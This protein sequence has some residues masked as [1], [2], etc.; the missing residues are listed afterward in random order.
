MLRFNFR[1]TE[2][3][4]QRAFNLGIL[5]AADK[6]LHKKRDSATSNQCF[7]FASKQK[8]STLASN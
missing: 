6:V 5:C 1:W 3:H 7:V 8:V 4:F 2:I